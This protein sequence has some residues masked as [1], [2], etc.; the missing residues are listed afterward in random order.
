MDRDQI[1][2]NWSEALTQPWTMRMEKNG[3]ST[4][5]SKVKVAEF[6]VQLEEGSRGW[7]HFWMNQKIS[8]QRMR[9]SSPG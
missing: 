7:D 2:T 1:R 3:K 8:V 9:C 4:D 6:C 5:I